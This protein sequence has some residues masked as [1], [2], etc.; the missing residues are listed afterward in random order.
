MRR[1]KPLIAFSAAFLFLS[2]LQVS[3]DSWQDN[4]FSLSWT[5]EAQE[6]IMTVS[7]R[8]T[9]WIAVGFNPT[10][11]MRDANIIIGAVLPDGTVVVEDH[12]GTGLTSHRKD[13][14][15][16]GTSNVRVI[17]G[18]E[19]NGSTTIT[20]AIPLNSGDSRD[21]ALTAGEK[22]VVI[23]A[24]AQRDGFTVKHNKRTKTEI[25]L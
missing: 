25:G 10:R 17:S 6:L 21:A 12:F 2:S 24:S 19:R 5:I 20:F 23:L 9:G 8:T 11:M 18:E 4:D 16:G 1:I 3:A 22:A 15:I 14:E 13:T 7:A